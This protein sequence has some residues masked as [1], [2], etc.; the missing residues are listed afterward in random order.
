MY[1]LIS[2]LFNKGWEYLYI[3][4]WLFSTISVD[5]FFTKK[6]RILTFGFSLVLLFFFT[7]FRWE[8]GTDWE[9]YYKL[10]DELELN[11]TFVVNVFNFDLGYVLFNAFV[12]I[13]SNNYTVFLI[14]DSLVA[15]GLIGLFLYRFSPLPNLSLFV[16]YNTY[17][18]STYMGSNR[19]IIALGLIQF[20]FIYFFRMQKLSGYKGVF[21][22]FLFHRTSFIS[23]VAKWVPRNLLRLKS[24]LLLLISAFFIGIFS[25]PYKTLGILAA[26]LSNFEHIP[27]I[28]K[29]I[30]YTDTE[31]NLSVISENLNTMI[32][33]TFST[34]KR[35]FFLGVF[36]LVIRKNI[37]N[38]DAITI[39][40]FNLYL[41]GFL[42]YMVFNGSPIFQILSVYFTFIEVVLTG[43]IIS[44]MKFKFKIFMYLLLLIYG[45]MQLL[46]AL[47]AY[48]ELYIPYKSAL[49]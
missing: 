4:L 16:F 5:F 42:L 22:A 21:V 44:F 19:R 43:R 33:F 41:L 32:L 39:Y 2:L 36:Y 25:L 12:R 9:S 27:T 37:R 38:I 1:N 6:F 40:F 49:Y 47:T 26:S 18:L 45:F 13:F 11:W 46:S 48:P 24:I 34:F 31:N 28:S 10:F 8:V 20:V 7:A 14:L 35:C 30:F 17:Y 15:I 3:F 23:I 29:L